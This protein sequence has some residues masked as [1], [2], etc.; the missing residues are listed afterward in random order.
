MAAVNPT[1]KSGKN[2]KVTVDS[3]AVSVTQWQGTHN[4]NTVETTSGPYEDH[5]PGPEGF[6]GSFEAFVPYGSTV[7]TAAPTVND[8]LPLELC[9]DSVSGVPAPTYSFNAIMDSVAPAVAVKDG[10]KYTCNFK[11]CGAITVS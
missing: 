4:G 6:Q 2:G 7:G 1:Y 11:S 5:V 3:N 10:V 9:E 8:I